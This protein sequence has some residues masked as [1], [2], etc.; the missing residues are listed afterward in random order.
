[1]AAAAHEPQKPTA[2][3]V[4]STTGPDAAAYGAAEGYPLGSRA[5]SEEVK[6]L[7]ATY[8]LFDDLFKSGIVIRAEEPWLFRRV[9]AEPKITR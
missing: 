1:M 8:S 2:G 4:S 5:T 7:V 6:H 9:S 3:P